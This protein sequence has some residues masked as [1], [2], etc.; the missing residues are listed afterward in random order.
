MAFD[1]LRGR[2]IIPPGR[3]GSPRR[4]AFSMSTTEQDIIIVGGAYRAPRWHTRLSGKG[5]KVTVLDAPTDTNKASRTNVEADLVP[6]EIP[7]LP[8]YAKWGFVSC[9]CT[10]R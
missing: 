3:S 8:E 2:G 9:G 10:R 1:A 4:Q 6:V 7:A 5:R